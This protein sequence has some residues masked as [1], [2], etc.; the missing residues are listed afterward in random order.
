MLNVQSVFSAVRLGPC[1]DSSACNIEHSAVEEIPDTW[2]TTM[3]LLIKEF[4]LYKTLSIKKKGLQDYERP[5]D[6]KNKYLTR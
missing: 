3:L 5:R 4:L 6:G 2:M 1:R